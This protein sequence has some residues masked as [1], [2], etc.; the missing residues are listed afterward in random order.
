M[1]PLT[2]ANDIKAF[3]STVT[4]F[5]TSQSTCKLTVA[6]YV[7]TELQNI[8][9]EAFN[10]GLSLCYFQFKHENAYNIIK[11]FNSDRTDHPGVRVFQHDLPEVIKIAIE[12]CQKCN[13]VVVQTSD[14]SHGF[15]GFIFQTAP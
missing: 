5:E 7:E 8:V 14:R 1:K 6:P 2:N 15:N 10:E 12:I 4:T 11:A 9:D 13:Y 3:N